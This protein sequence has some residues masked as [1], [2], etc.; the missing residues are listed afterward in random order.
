M[1]VA[2]EQ[3]GYVVEVP[4]PNEQTVAAWQIALYILSHGYE[5]R[6]G[7]EAIS[8]R[9]LVYYIGSAYATDGTRDWLT[10]STGVDPRNLRAMKALLREQLDL[11]LTKP[12]LQAEIDAARSHLLG[13]SISA[14]QSNRELADALARQW[15]FSQGLESTDELRKRL[16]DTTRDD[17]LAIL[18]AFVR[19]TIA[20][21]RDPAAAPWCSSAASSQNWYSPCAPRRS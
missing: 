13:R 12:P 16:S 20:P 1:P 5:G 19:G 9:G 21:S 6:L 3:L 7:K 14:A 18:P 8:R 4:E 2:Q 10:L 11:L 15:V 17:V